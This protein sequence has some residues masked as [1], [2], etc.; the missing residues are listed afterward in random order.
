MEKFIIFLPLVAAIISG[1]FGKAI[2]NRASQILT[3]LFVTISALLSIYILY[4]VI[5]NGYINNVVIGK[6]ISS[7]QLK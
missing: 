4:K 3:S 7:G 1:F 6:W 5:N 2:G